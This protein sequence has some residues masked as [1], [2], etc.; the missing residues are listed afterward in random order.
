LT[1][2]RSTQELPKPLEA[3]TRGLLATTCLTAA[4]GASAM[5]ATINEG[6]TPAPTDFPDL[7]SNSFVLPIGTTQVFGFVGAR[8]GVEGGVHDAADWFTFTGLTGNGSYTLTGQSETGVQL[9]YSDSSLS[10][11]GSLD[12]GENSTQ[13]LSAVFT[14]PSDGKLVVE[15]Y[16]CCEGSGTYSVSLAANSSATPEPAT[17]GAVGLGL[18]A[19]ALAWRRRRAS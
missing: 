5:A 10:V 13:P 9:Q 11:L 2:I 1:K 7:G 4:C 6:T 8:S 18:G 16:D 14:A 3:F 17:A 19:I 15:L 12:I